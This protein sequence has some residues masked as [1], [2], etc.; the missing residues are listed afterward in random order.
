MSLPRV[1][2]IVLLAGCEHQYVAIPGAEVIPGPYTTTHDPSWA[3]TTEPTAVFTEGDGVLT[4]GGSPTVIHVDF[5]NITEIEV[6]AIVIV[7]VDFS[8]NELS[9]MPGHWERP[10]TEEEIEEGAVDIEVVALPEK[11][12]KEWCFR[13]YRGVGTCY[14][15]LDEGLTGIGVSAASDEQLTPPQPLPVLLD[16]LVEPG[17]GDCALYTFE[18]CCGCTWDPNLGTNICPL[19]CYVPPPCGCASGTSDRGTFE[20]MNACVCP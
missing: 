14:Q 19:E 10:L 4:P 15:E 17:G 8:A 18:E 5:T 2:L 16:P 12:K 13:D 7:G 3:G 11:P 9:A 6:T 1:A 20:G